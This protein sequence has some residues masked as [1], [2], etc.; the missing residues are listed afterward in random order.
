VRDVTAVGSLGVLILF[1]P[2]VV[3]FL[4]LQGKRHAAPLVIVAVG[5]RMLVSTF[6]KLGFGRPRPDPVPDATEAYTAL[7][8]SLS[9]FCHTL[10]TSAAGIWRSS[11][12][13]KTA[14]RSSSRLNLPPTWTSN[15]ELQMSRNSWRWLFASNR[16]T[17]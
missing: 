15:P 9:G 11:R 5:G 10:A 7:N 3:G 13:A 8:D 2:A 12:A 17:E 1:S 4:M 16:S 6:T 14:V